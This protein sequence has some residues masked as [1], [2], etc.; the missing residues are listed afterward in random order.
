MDEDSEIFGSLMA[1]YVSDKIDE[2]ADRKTQREIAKEVGYR[3]PNI[4]SMFKSGETKIPLPLVIPLARAI[5]GDPAYMF[6]L[7]IK[8]Q[9]GN[10]LDKDIAAVFGNVVSASEAEMI[11]VIRS[12][13]G[14]RDISVTPAVVEHLKQLKDVV[15]MIDKRPSPKPA[16]PASEDVEQVDPG[17]QDLNFKVAPDLHFRFK[18][19]AT[20]RRLSM[21]ELFELCFN[22]FLETEGQKQ[23][24]LGK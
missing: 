21:K 7:A 24:G 23:S 2:L 16:L 22:R 10:L 14:H 18:M 9:F 8:Q 3:R 6:N 19:E 4:I 13:T 15:N 11:E 17:V 12:A 20:R 5:E 1:Q